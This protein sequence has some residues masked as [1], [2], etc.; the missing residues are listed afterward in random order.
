M[1][2]KLTKIGKEFFSAQ[3]A[4]EKRLEQIKQE[5]ELK[6]Q[7]LKVDEDIIENLSKARDFG[8]ELTDIEKERLSNLE[9]GKIISTEVVSLEKKLTTQARSTNK[10]KS[11][12]A[13]SASI[14]L[15]NLK[16]DFK[17]TAMSEESF[18]SQSAIIQQIA[19]GS[20]T[21]EEIQSSITDLSED[22]ATGM[23]KYLESQKES[24][25]TQDF[26]KD[27]MSSMDG[28][29]GGFAGKIKGFLTNP[30]T[31]AVA[32][33]MTF[34]ATQEDIANQ[35]GALGV[36]ELRGDL[37]G[38]SEEF[39]KFGKTGADAQLAISNL[40]NE[41]GV[42]VQESKK[43]SKNVLD[44]SI[45]TATT[46]E[47][48]A[49]LVGLF[50]QTQGLTGEQAENLLIS[51]T[52]LANANNVA[53]DKVLADVAQNTEF[54]A[55][56]AQDGGENILRASIQARKL[57]LDLQKVA[58][59]SNSLLDF[60]SSL[61]NE[62]TASVMLGR[63]INLQ[64]AREL[65]LNNDIEG[66]MVEVVK[67]V[68]SEAEFNKLNALE[69]QALADAVGLQVGDIQK[70]VNKEKESVTLASEL[71]KQDISNL[72]PEETITQTAQLIGQLTSLGVA[73]SEVLGP[74]LSFIMSIFTET[75]K[76]ISFMTLGLTDAI[77]PIGAIGV[78]MALMGKKMLVSAVMGVWS[79][80][81]SV[82]KI[83]VIGVPLA[84]AMGI[85]ATKAIYKSLTTAKSKKAGDM[86]SPAL[87]KTQVSTKE[88]ELFELSKNDDIMAAPGLA[89]AMGG[90]TQS[91]VSIDTSGIEK[92]NVQVKNE[93]SEL[94]KEMKEYFGFGGRVASQI[95]SKVGDKLIT[96]LS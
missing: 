81:Q 39:Q 29:M 2:K 76:V 49:K 7:E 20:A 47:D 32:I 38:A 15:A 62:I 66:A 96:S 63:D 84:I 52:A 18:K 79:G 53:P 42:S 85:G 26:A 70:L 31:A 80:L 27:A 40:S 22:S 71:A 11:E 1:A 73:L 60:Q 34:N 4:Q 41:F 55:K 13:K 68:G 65:A 44:T 36:T 83:P 48:T 93:M 54:F 87:G 75:A 94:R 82:M 25:Q 59:V 61:N 33:L 43:L 86:I 45:V 50:T 6:Q 19:A 24:L 95:G 51:T 92:G 35:F 69:R 10:I 21:I 72:I 37:A 91:S 90:G 23:K 57:G 16:K 88:G 8:I 89:S 9:K 17:E 64:K 56:F 14:Q 78:A 12:R 74:P 58:T 67:Q 3:K 5:V 28:I 30:L 77:G 46:L